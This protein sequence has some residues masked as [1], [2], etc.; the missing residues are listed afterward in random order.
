MAAFL[1]DWNRGMKDMHFKI[2]FKM[3]LRIL[4]ENLGMIVVITLLVYLE[5]YEEEMDP[6][7]SLVHDIVRSFILLTLKLF[8]DDPLSYGDRNMVK[9][10]TLILMSYIYI[11]YKVTIFLY[12]YFC[13]SI[14]ECFK[15]WNR[16]AKILFQKKIANISDKT[17]DMEALANDHFTL[18]RLVQD[19]DHVFGLVITAYVFSQVVIVIFTIYKVMEFG[20]NI[21]TCWLTLIVLIPST[22]LLL[23]VATTAS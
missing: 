4:S 5:F 21:K 6:P 19:L 18:V 3:I 17:V 10:V 20:I 1:S 7:S 22:V 12:T 2:T 15:K 13:S 8:M 16:K 9:V 23:Y 11:S 14:S